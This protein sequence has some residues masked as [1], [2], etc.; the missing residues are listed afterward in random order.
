MMGRPFKAGNAADDLSLS[1]TEKSL[2]R[3]L[4]GDPTGQLASRGIWAK[5]WAGLACPWML[6]WRQHRSMS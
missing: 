5:I 1:Y 6:G 4:P 2:T 3:R